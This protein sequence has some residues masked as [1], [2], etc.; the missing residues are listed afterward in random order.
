MLF[1]SDNGKPKPGDWQLE[2]AGFVTD[3]E[4][5]DAVVH[6]LSRIRSGEIHN[7][8]YEG[9]F[10][11]PAAI[12][13][14]TD[15]KGVVTTITLGGRQ[16]EGAS[17]IRVSGRDEV[18]RVAANVGTVMQLPKEAFRDRRLMTFERADVAALAWSD[19][20][21]T[22]VLDQGVD[23][24]WT[25]SQP[26]NMDADQRLAMSAVNTFASLR[27]AGIAPDDTFHATGARFEVRFQIGRAHV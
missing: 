4:T 16:E 11:T 17:L 27:A 2:G 8:D 20:A 1:R 10:A 24:V 12:A 26:A 13:S 6:V 22:V 18:F 3:T 23:D 7:A 15:A 25:V 9:G 5:V 21:L 14:L 19:G